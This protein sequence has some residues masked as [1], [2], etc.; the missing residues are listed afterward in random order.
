MSPA[1]ASL[2]VAARLPVVGSMLHYLRA[3]LPFLEDTARRGDIVRMDFVHQR[4]WL[5]SDPAMAELVFVKTAAN[6]QKD[7]FLRA[8]KRVLGEG[9]LSSEGAF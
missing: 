1:N 3:P 6:F 8:L 5:V 7:V 2:P 9:L 4:A